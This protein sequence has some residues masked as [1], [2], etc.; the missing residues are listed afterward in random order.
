MSA[1]STVFKEASDLN[2]GFLSVKASNAL[3]AVLDHQPLSDDERQ[4]LHRAA[5]F[6]ED[7][8]DG[9]L[10]AIEG[11]F[12]QGARDDRSMDAL[13]YALGPID[14]LKELA[15]EENV[16]VLFANMSKAVHCAAEAPTQAQTEDMK[17]AISFFDA[18]YKLIVRD[19][20]AERPM[21]GAGSSTRYFAQ[22]A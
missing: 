9:A 14:T 4:D 22:L 2:F 21:L 5:E 19:L 15:Q 13:S 12:R 16:S 3:S 18:L 17:V 6:L 11:T 10:V 20:Q 7:V 8:A 1:P